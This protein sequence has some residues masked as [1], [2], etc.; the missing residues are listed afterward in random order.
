MIPRRKYKG[1]NRSDAID[2]GEEE[3]KYDLEEAKREI[4]EYEPVIGKNTEF[5]TQE[6]PDELLMEIAG[7]FETKEY[8]VQVAKDKYKVKGTIIEEGKE[9]IEVVIRIFKVPPKRYCV[10]VTRNEGD[11]LEFFN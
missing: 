9:P 1:D 8:K 3:K 5:F 4:E 2:E 11:Q 6:N 7:Y 10:E